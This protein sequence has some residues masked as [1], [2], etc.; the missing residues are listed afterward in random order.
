MGKGTSFGLDKT[1]SLCWSK[2]RVCITSIIGRVD[3]HHPY[4]DVVEAIGE[5]LYIQN[6]VCSL[7]HSNTSHPNNDLLADIATGK[8]GELY[9]TSLKVA[10]PHSSPRCSNLTM[11]IES[12]DDSG[13]M[14]GA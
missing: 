4:M 5:S 12:R 11:M 7:R 14:R 10:E 1:D 6:R 3:M 2:F 13:S 9:K 8:C